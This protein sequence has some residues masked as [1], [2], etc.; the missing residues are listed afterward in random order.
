[1]HKIDNTR[2]NPSH[3]SNTT[4]DALPDEILQQILSYTQLD[5]LIALNQTCTRFR[6]FLKASDASFI[7]D[8]VLDRVPWMVPNYE[9]ETWIICGRLIVERERSLNEE[10]ED[11]MFLDGS[12]ESYRK[13]TELTKNNNTDIKYVSVKNINHGGLPE[14]FEP[15]FGSQS[16]WQRNGD[17]QG[18]YMS[19]DRCY[20]DASTFDWVRKVPYTEEK[21]DSWYG[22]A[23]GGSR[24]ESLICVCP[25]SKLK[26]TEANSKFFVLV[27]ETKH[28]LVIKAEQKVHLIDKRLATKDNELVFEMGKGAIVWEY[29]EDDRPITGEFHRESSEYLVQFLPDDLRGAFVLKF[30]IPTR[31]TGLHYLDLSSKELRLLATF[32]GRSS[33]YNWRPHYSRSRTP[34]DFVVTYEGTLWLHYREKELIPLWVDFGYS[35]VDSEGA[36]VSRDTST[37]REVKPF[38]A[39]SRYDFDTLRVRSSKSPILKTGF[40]DYR[41]YKSADSRFVTNPAALG[42]IVCDLATQITYIVR[43]EHNTLYPGAMFIDLD[44]ELGNPVFYTFTDEFL[45]ALETTWMD[46][47][48]VWSDVDSEEEDDEPVEYSKERIMQCARTEMY[49]NDYLYHSEDEEIDD[50]EEW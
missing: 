39:G 40:R 19:I 22:Y 5:A 7:R 1:M 17:I 41:L 6:A 45:A 23:C 50:Q 48:H 9:M 38:P 28:W 47:E 33:D 34:R 29:E 20:L 44:P 31:T 37:S 2:T 27:Q 49:R 42:R 43:D 10:R 18:R 13:L 26:V 15:L 36:S 4:M 8:K 11:W 25:L 30:N 24:Y 35:E 32:P 21:P 12:R 16:F 14:S 3:L 46:P